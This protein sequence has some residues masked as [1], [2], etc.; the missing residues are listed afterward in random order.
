MKSGI[1]CCLNK[2]LGWIGQLRVSLQTLPATQVNLKNVI[3]FSRLVFTG[4]LSQFHTGLT[5]R[6]NGWPV[7]LLSNLWKLLLECRSCWEAVRAISA[8][9]G[10]LQRV[11]L[12]MKGR[13]YMSFIDIKTSECQRFCW[14]R[15]V[16]SHLHVPDSV[17]DCAWMCL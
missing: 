13:R 15:P 5:Y 2:S 10:N 1:K 9:S 8:S 12:R 3:L 16:H 14:V 11:T 7:C 17:T 6:C 4:W